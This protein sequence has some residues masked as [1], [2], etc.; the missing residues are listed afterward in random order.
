MKTTRCIKGVKP[1]LR[2]PDS[3]ASPARS[4]GFSLIESLFSL[5]L[6]SFAVIGTAGLQGSL[7]GFSQNSQYRAEASFYAE[8]LVGLATADVA[9]ANC[10]ALQA[11]CTNTD[12]YTAATNWW[13]TVIDALPGADTLPPT[14]A[15]NAAT[16]E[17]AVTVFWQRPGD[18]TTRNFTVNTVVRQ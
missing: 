16:G 7:V 14:L 10:Y 4:R 13:N 17:L 15:Y 6:F 12:A 5:T 18:D 8:Q 11:G 2:T 1:P 3:G 9:N